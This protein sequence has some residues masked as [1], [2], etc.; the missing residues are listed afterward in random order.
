MLLATI[1][2]TAG[3]GIGLTMALYGVIMA[4]SIVLLKILRLWGKPKELF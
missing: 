1:Q 4:A 3:V 2:L